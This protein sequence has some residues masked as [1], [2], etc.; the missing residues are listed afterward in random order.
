MSF[1]RRLGE[2]DILMT[3]TVETLPGTAITLEEFRTAGITV[4]GS[5]YTELPL[6]SGPSIPIYMSPS[7]GGIHTLTEPNKPIE[8]VANLGAQFMNAEIYY[9]GDQHSRELV[10]HNEL[11]QTASVLAFTQPEDTLVVPLH[12]E[13]QKLAVNLVKQSWENA[14]IGVSQNIEYRKPEDINYLNG[15]TPFI[16]S[17]ETLV[18]KGV[19]VKHAFSQV[20]AYTKDGSVLSWID[21]H[22]PVPPTLFLKGS[23]AINGGLA[24]S[25]EELREWE[26]VVINSTN[27]SGGFGIFFLQREQLT[28]PD[29]IALFDRVE[30]LTLQIQPHLALDHSPCVIATI[31]GDGSFTIQ[32]VSE[33]RFASPGAHGGNIWYE[34]I[35]KDVI[36]PG[37]EK[38]VT[39][40]IQSLVSRGI[41]GQIN[42]DFLDIDKEYATRHSMAPFLVREANIRPAGSSVQIRMRDIDIN[43]APVKRIHTKTGIMVSKDILTDGTVFKIIEQLEAVFENTKILIYSANITADSHS[44][45]HIGLLSNK[46]EEAELSN[47]ESAFLSL[48]HGPTDTMR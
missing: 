19:D 3:A 48:I 36:P 14:G 46:D 33:Q 2:N 25:A 5:P 43:G 18:Q 37:G 4:L 11:T 12:D 16:I 45:I 17:P 44:T 9:C 38:I 21:D 30:N 15:S 20:A 40:A 47:L 7:R 13:G 23:D 27:G 8:L 29:T 24:K 41:R 26:G 28:D 10:A 22:V 1:N 31:Q 34:G 39:A 35:E 42:L 32:H 6:S